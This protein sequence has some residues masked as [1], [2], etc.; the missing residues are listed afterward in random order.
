MSHAGYPGHGAWHA[1]YSTRA[2]RIRD[3]CCPLPP[4][5]G[6][7]TRR[8]S[9]A[10]HHC[11]HQPQHIEGTATHVGQKKHDPNAAPKLWAQGTADHILLESREDVSSTKHH[12]MLPSLSPRPRGSQPQHGTPRPL[13]SHPALSHMPCPS[14]TH[15]KGYSKLLQHP[16]PHWWQWHTQ[17][18]P[19]CQ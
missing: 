19:S 16:A 10:V 12:Q 3:T 8:D 7:L 4:R 5:R 17:I 15:S 13:G 1:W 18:A 2:A 14:S 6:V 9:K 11:L